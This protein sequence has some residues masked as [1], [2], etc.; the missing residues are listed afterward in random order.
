MSEGGDVFGLCTVPFFH[1]AKVKALGNRRDGAAAFE[2]KEA[3]MQDWIINILNQFGYFGIAALI[4]IE[5]IFPPIPSEVILTFGGFMTTYTE[6]NEWMVIL[7]ATAGSL[8]GA[9]LLYEVGSLVSQ[10]WLAKVLQGK[11]GKILRL[12]PGDVYRASDWFQ[13]KGYAAVLICR[14]IPIVRSLISI[15]AGM[16]RMKLLPFFL[17]TTLG[18]VIWNT[19][20]IWLGS[21][22]GASWKQILTVFDTYALA[23]LGIAVVCAVVIGLLAYRKKGLRGK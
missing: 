19:A 5:N 23:V 2:I 18:S 12:K 8:V 6:M 1:I 17:L 11:T 10:E 9:V 20:L 13:K 3:C 7:A 21:L 4:A 22:A 15:P 14:F 16:A